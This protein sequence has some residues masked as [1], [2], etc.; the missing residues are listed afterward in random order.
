MGLIASTDT[1]QPPNNPPEWTGTPN[2]NFVDSVAGTYE[3]SDDTFDQESDSLTY[4]LNSGSTALPTGVTI[5]GS[6]LV[7]T[8]SVAESVTAGVIIDV[9]DADS[10]LI[11]SPSFAIVISEAPPITPPT[12]FDDY[13]NNVF[14]GE[15]GALAKNDN[16][17]STIYDYGPQFAPDMGATETPTGDPAKP[18]VSGENPNKDDEFLVIDRAGLAAVLN[19]PGYRLI[20]LAKGSDCTNGNDNDNMNLTI[21]GVDGTERKFLYWDDITPANV[22][23]IAPWNQA[24]GDRVNMPRITFDSADYTWLIGLSWGKIGSQL[25]KCALFQGTSSH[26]IHYRCNMENSTAHCWNVNSENC[27]NNI[28]FVCVNHDHTNGTG[29]IHCFIENKGTNT[30]IISC[31]GWD[32]LGDFLQIGNG[33]N[34]GGVLEDCD[35]YRKTFYDG[36]GNVDPNGNF[37][38]GEGAAD[39]KNLNTDTTSRFKMYGNRIWD[40]RKRDPIKHPAG[41]SGAAAA[42]S[43][44]SVAKYGLDCRWNVIFDCYDT[45]IKLSGGDL[46]GGFHSVVRNIL[47]NIRANDNS[48]PVLYL[49]QKTTEEYLNTVVDCLASTALLNYFRSDATDIDVHDS[50]GNFYQDTTGVENQSFWGTNFKRGYNAYAGTYTLSNKSYGNDFEA[51]SKAALN[52]GD[53]TFRRKKL[54]IPNPTI[55]NGGLVVIPGI[56]PT[57]NTPSGFLTLVPTAGN[58]QIGTRT[59]IGVDDVS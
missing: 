24:Q 33:V 22:I 1:V 15:A 28:A 36:N 10:A 35:I 41:A 2:P 51:V 3:L 23:G 8:N 46:T 49:N 38:A 32:Y 47:S 20:F 59:G 42:F 11:A 39:F 40:M 19:D 50:M 27:D 9:K 12:L 26:N 29:D 48:R 21:S 57:S 5:S 31:E 52:M 34:N 55:E 25:M 16:W 14:A 17:A 4:T 18:G 43:N 6:Q 7:A 56:V 13:S 54:T 53:F 45:G 30:K 37:T 58:D 44:N